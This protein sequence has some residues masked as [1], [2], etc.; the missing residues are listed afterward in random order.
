MIRRRNGNKGP[1]A[2]GGWS[3]FHTWWSGVTIDNPVTNILLR[4]LGEEGYAGWYRD[5][6]IEALVAQW[7]D[8]ASPAAERQ[9]ADAILRQVMDQLP[10]IPLGMTYVFTAYR[11]NLAGILPGVAPFPWNVRR[12]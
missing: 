2:Q 6:K 9:S 12:S 11:K 7:L 8:A 1:V 3:V 5:D 10:T 4:G